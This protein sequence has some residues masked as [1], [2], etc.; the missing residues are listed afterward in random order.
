VVDKGKRIS[1]TTAQN[2][3]RVIEAMQPGQKLI[4]KRLGDTVIWQPAPAPAKPPAPTGSG[5]K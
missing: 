3:I 1:V 4:V 5:S 2:L